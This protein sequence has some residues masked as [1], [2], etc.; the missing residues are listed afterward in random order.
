MIVYPSIG[1]FEFEFNDVDF[2][3][4]FILFVIFCSD[5]KGER[6]EDVDEFEVV[7]CIVDVG[8]GRTIE[9]IRLAV[10][11]CVD[12]RLLHLKENPFYDRKEQFQ[13]SF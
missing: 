7:V 11:R 6:F 8:I 4:N 12:I 9:R 2:T 5:G 10:I 13:I 1:T 3:S